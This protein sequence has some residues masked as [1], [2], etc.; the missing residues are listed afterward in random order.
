L[1]SLSAAVAV[2]ASS[3]IHILRF[4]SGIIIE[5]SIEQWKA[6]LGER[7][8][9]VKEVHQRCQKLQAD[10]STKPSNFMISAKQTAIGAMVFMASF[11]FYFLMEHN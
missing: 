3:Y 11:A 7:E 8:Q 2:L 1:F 6:L 10:A 4:S 5:L 9:I